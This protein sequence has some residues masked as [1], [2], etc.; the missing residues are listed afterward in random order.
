MH[1]RKRSPRVWRH[2]HR[3]FLELALLL[4]VLGEVTRCIGEPELSLALFIVAAPLP[5][6]HL[7]RR[8]LSVP[9][10]QLGQV[11]ISGFGPTYSYY[12]SA[13]RYRVTTK[14]TRE[15]ENAAQNSAL[16]QRRF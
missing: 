5:F 3:P 12:L 1:R 7:V 2:C 15:G 13:C 10:R 4:G 16:S 8:Y 14:R 11:P 6:L 9:P